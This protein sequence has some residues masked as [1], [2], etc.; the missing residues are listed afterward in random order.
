LAAAG[1]SSLRNTLA[2]G[3]AVAGVFT[4]TDIRLAGEPLGFGS[5]SPTVRCSCSM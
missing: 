5:P 2:L 4:L 1:L 3:L